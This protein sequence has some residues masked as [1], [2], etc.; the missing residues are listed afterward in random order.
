MLCTKVR[1]CWIL[2]IVVVVGGEI[3]D[4][5]VRCV[6]DQG[7]LLIIGFASGEI[8]KIAANMPLI[9]G[10][11][12]VGVRAGASIRLHPHLGKDLNDALQKL[13]NDGKLIPHV[14]HVYGMTDTRIS[15]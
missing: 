14:D 3:F 4:K 5:C 1:I 11:S 10:F 2:L 6:A 12:V 7:R 13:T 9:K 8:P 15:N